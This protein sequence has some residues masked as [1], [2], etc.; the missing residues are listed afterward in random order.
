MNLIARTRPD[1]PTRRWHEPF[2]KDQ[3]GNGLRRAVKNDL[4]F[5]Q[6]AEAVRARGASSETGHVE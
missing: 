6:A 5:G 2:P 3:T 1:P 4:G